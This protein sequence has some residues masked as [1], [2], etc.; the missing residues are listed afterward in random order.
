MPKIDDAQREARRETLL[1]AARDCMARDGWRNLT[2]DEVC[3]TAGAS[4]GMFY[5]YFERKEDL[6]FALLEE[7]S[8]SLDSLLAEVE[9]CIVIGDP[10]ASPVPAG[11]DGAGT[12]PLHPQVRADLW[13]ELR[14]DPALRER[15]VAGAGDR[16]RTLARWISQAVESNELHE[17]PANALAS[18]LIALSD[19]LMLYYAVDPAAFKWRNVRT[20]VDILLDSLAAREVDGGPTAETPLVQVAEGVRRPGCPRPL[21]RWLAWSGAQVVSGEEQVHGRW[22]RRFR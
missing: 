17:V 15:F 16:R 8:A 7:D 11:D 5:T 18:M 9:G 20:A 10:A 4:K 19:G 13:A 14:Y 3:S 21:A 12:D 2:I 6:L 22:R 1:A